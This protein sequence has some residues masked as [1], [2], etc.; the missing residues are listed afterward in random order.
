[1][2]EQNLIVVWCDI[3]STIHSSSWVRRY[4]QTRNSIQH[5]HM[6]RYAEKEIDLQQQPA[7]QTWQYQTF[8][9]SNT[10]QKQC[11]RGSITHDLYIV[12][13]HLMWIKESLLYL[14][15]GWLMPIPKDICLNHI[16]AALLALCNQARPHLEK[17]NRVPVHR[18]LINYT[19]DVNVDAANLPTNPMASKERH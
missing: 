17:K 16:R 9:Q 3:V 10:G 12:L 6:V 15:F 8:L 1:M 4:K 5:K 13:C 18:V 11:F 14:A 19:N 2:I 7:S